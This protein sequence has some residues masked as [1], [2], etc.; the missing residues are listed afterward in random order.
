[1]RFWYVLLFLSF[2]S[3]GQSLTDSQKL[4][5]LS[6]V[7][8]FLKYYHPT[9]ATGK[10]NWDEQ[11]ISLLP[12]VHQAHNRDDLS[13]IYTQLIDKLGAVKP[14]KK[15]LSPE[16]F[17]DRLKRNFDLTLLNDSAL[18]SA[19]LRDRL[20]YIA[21]NRNQD[22]NHYVQWVRQT[23][24]TSYG[25]ENPYNELRKPD[26]A[27]R[28]LALFRYW[29]IVQ[30]FF[31]YKY[32]IDE[33]WN[34]VLTTLIPV[35]QQATS[36]QAYQLAIYRMVAQ[37]QDSHGV[38]SNTNKTICLRCDLGRYWVPFGVTILDDKAVIT[39]FYNDSLAAL[40]KL[41]I[42]M[43]IS[44]I[45]GETI[46]AR[47][48]RELPYIA[49]SNQSARLRNVAS[50][51]SIGPAEQVTLTIEAGNH[52][53]VLTVHRYAY[54]AFGTQAM[55]SINSRNPLSRWLPD[56]IGYVNMGQ[57]K[58]HQVDSVM[59]LFMAAKAIIFDV[60]NYPQGTLGQVLS[61]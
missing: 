12:Q 50:L 59:Q 52:D 35:F 11:L 38:V 22:K 42:G 53:S 60:R 26:E 15:C 57:L 41:K 48:E 23:E 2:S 51:I 29:N 43:V 20:R 58:T 44:H 33:N 6:K 7:W 19:P 49:A 1:M 28:L 24:N 18:F 16:N 21:Q 56:S 27:H 14:C 39:R 54:S 32:A 40:N 13:F 8:G 31:P 30:Y 34:D 55:E 10:Q 3:S 17:P 45:D 37:I 36:E 25:N 5:S 4:A 9:V 46:R 61:T 47:T